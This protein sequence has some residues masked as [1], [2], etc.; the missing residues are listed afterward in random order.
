MKVLL[1]TS[2]V[3]SLTRGREP[4]VELIRDAL[5]NADIYITA[6]TELELL[7]GARD[8]MDWQELTN[9]VAK[10]DV[11]APAPGHWRDAARC[12]FELRRVG[13][14]VRSSLDCLIA[15]VAMSHSMQLV[16]DDRDFEKI[17]LLRPL[18]HR[19][20]P[21]ISMSGTA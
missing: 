21:L 12:F 15:E 1:D 17:A 11:I 9:F 14:T 4:L 13:Q 18:D 8:H 20:L 16:H 2:I 3:I 7:Q 6:L 19:R 10:Q 5:S